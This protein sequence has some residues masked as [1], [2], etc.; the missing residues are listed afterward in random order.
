VLNDLAE[1]SVFVTNDFAAERD[2]KILERNGEQ[3][4]AMK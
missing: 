1:K 2:V 4:R 3:V